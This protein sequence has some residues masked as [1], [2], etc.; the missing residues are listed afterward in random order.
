[1][2]NKREDREGNVKIS[3]EAAAGIQRRSDWLAQRQLTVNVRGKGYTA[4]ILKAGPSDLLKGQ[5]FRLE[6]LKMYLS[7]AEAEEPRERS[8]LGSSGICLGSC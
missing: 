5:D 7:F 1:M 2:K 6:Q 3:W 8:S 4:C